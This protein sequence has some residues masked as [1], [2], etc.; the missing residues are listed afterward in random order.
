MLKSCLLCNYTIFADFVTVA[1]GGLG[2]WQ[3]ETQGGKQKTFNCRLL[4]KPPCKQEFY[5]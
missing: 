3:T 1:G 5:L 4:I 2:C